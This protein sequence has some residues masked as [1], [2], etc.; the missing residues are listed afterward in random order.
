[1]S[2]TKFFKVIDLSY[3]GGCSS[4]AFKINL[5]DLNMNMHI[6]D[7]ATVYFL[8]ECLN[9]EAKILEALYRAIYFCE[10]KRDVAQ[11]AKEIN[12]FIGV[13]LR[14]SE[15]GGID[16]GFCTDEGNDLLIRFPFRYL[17]NAQSL[18]L[19]GKVAILKT[20]DSS[21]EVCKAIIQELIMAFWREFCNH[22]TRKNNSGPIPKEILYFKDQEGIKWVPRWY[23]RVRAFLTM[24]KFWHDPFLSWLEAERWFVKQGFQFSR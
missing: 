15:R 13:Y 23:I 1:M 21:I 4:N 9:E 7:R 2:F 14:D 6:S 8:E 22:P 24:H 19:T 3:V 11:I 16:I 5:G 12:G 20:E 18:V 10:R 17:G